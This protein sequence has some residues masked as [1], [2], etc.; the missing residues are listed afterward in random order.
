MAENLEDK[1]VK[2]EKKLG[3]SGDVSPVR[4][5][6]WHLD[7]IESLIGGSGSSG[8]ESK[9]ESLFDYLQIGFNSQAHIILIFDKKLLKTDNIIVNINE[10]ISTLNQMGNLSIPTYTKLE[11]LKDIA[12]YLNSLDTQAYAQIKVMFWASLFS[13]FPYL[14]L[15][16]KGYNNGVTVPVLAEGIADIN[17]Q[18][19][20]Y[21]IKFMNL[22][23]QLETVADEQTVTN[24]N[25]WVNDMD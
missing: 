18:N 9:A 1:L 8:S 15:S 22:N 24:F 17:N 6:G 14:S 19:F 13:V 25:V 3:G 16:I 5:L 10:L 12:F 7:N 23:G 20:A 4:D 2:I 21:T 11:D